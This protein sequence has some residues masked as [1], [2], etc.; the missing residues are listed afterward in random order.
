[1]QLRD[2]RIIHD[3]N[4]WASKR[5]LMAAEKLT[6]DQFMAPAAFPYS[7]LRGTPVHILDTEHSRRLLV[8]QALRRGDMGDT[9]LPNRDRL[10]IRWLVEELEIHRLD[11]EAGMRT[12]LACPQGEDP[13][14]PIRLIN[15]DT[16]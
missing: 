10:E 7:G 14:G 12:Y 3:Y 6:Q 13:A 2:I 9:E 15:P 5:L 8:Q 11:E 4:Y 16:A 1:M